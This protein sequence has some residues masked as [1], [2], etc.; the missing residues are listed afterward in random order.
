MEPALIFFLKEKDREIDPAHDPLFVIVVVLVIQLFIQT[1]TATGVRMSVV[2]RD[3]HW[4]VVLPAAILQADLP[5]RHRRTKD[6]DGKEP[7]SPS[8]HP[9]YHL[10]PAPCTTPHHPA[11][12]YPCPPDL[13]RQI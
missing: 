7:L 8:L 1:R 12:L 10:C 9:A 5:A 2:Q 13:E 4:A 11:Y 3:R 6:L